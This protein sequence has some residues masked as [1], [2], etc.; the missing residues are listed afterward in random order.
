MTEPHGK[1]CQ[2]CMT[3]EYESFRHDCVHESMLKNDAWS[4]KFRVGSW[5]RWNYEMDDAILVFSD[6]HGKARVICSMQVVGTTEDCSW[7]WAWGNANL[8]EAC[9]H[10]MDEVRAFGE[11]KQ[12]Q[13]MTELFLENDEYLGWECSAIASHLLGGIAV[14]RGP[15]SYKNGAVWMVILECRFVQ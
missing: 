13:Q 1:L 6:D 15:S 8:P 2:N 14:Y 7:E 5:S 3:E 4:E 12:W 10:R 11:E 9:K